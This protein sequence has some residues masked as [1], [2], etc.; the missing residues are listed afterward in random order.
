MLKYKLKT[1]QGDIPIEI[2]YKNFLLSSHWKHIREKVLHRDKHRCI[3]CDTRDF[4]Q[5]H[6][7]VYD[8]NIGEEELNLDKLITLCRDCHNKKHIHDKINSNIKTGW[9]RIYMKSYQDVLLVLKSNLEIQLFLA[10]QKTISVDYKLIINQTHL[11]KKYKCSRAIV[12]SL[13]KRLLDIEFLKKSDGIYISNPFIFTP[14]NT[15]RSST[16]K[17]QEDWNKPINA[18]DKA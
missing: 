5:V 4:L 17:A 18:N 9:S 12:T 3:E 1:Q 16:E 13:I 2:N 7:V 6:H 11:A 8:F 10:I 15:P 14:Y